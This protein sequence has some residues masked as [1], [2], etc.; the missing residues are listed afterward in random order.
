MENRQMAGD[1]D[2]KYLFEARNIHKRFGGVHALKGV[3]FNV[4]RG[5]IHGLV[6]ENGAGKSTLIKVISGIEQ[7]NE[8]ELLYNHHPISFSS[9]NDAM[10][11]GIA[12][13]HQEMSLFL[14]RTVAQ[15][16]FC[17]QEQKNSIG[18]INWAR[19]NQE[20]TDILAQLGVDLAP[21]TL[22]GDLSVADRQSIEIAKALTRKPDL[23]IMD[24]PT[25]ALARDEIRQLFDLLER[26]KQSGLTI[27]F[28][29]HKLDEVIEIC[30]HITVLR[31]GNVIGDLRASQTDIDSVIE[32][33]VGRK[34]E[35]MFPKKSRQV[36]RRLLS[37]KSFSLEGQFKNISFDLFEDEVLG[38]FGLLGAG[39]TPLAKAICGINP[40]DSG[41][42]IIGEEKLAI[43]QP[44]DAIKNGLL[45]MTEDR[46]HEGLFLLLSVAQN[47]LAS[48][49][50]KYARRGFLG[51]KKSR[52]VAMSYVD[53]LR[54]ATPGTDTLVAQLSGGNQQKVLLGKI[55]GTEPR[56]L[57]V[58]EPTRGIDV[59]AK[60]EIYSWLR[61]LANEGVGVIV[62][63]AE[64]PEIL[65]MADRVMVMHRGECK[66]F[67]KTEGATEESLLGM[68]YAPAATT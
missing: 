65:G 41:E 23:L 8:G 59:G 47:I 60:A 50:R 9:P 27:I 20:A 68:C 15:N 28:I 2:G 36:G 6:G 48:S 53:L 25:S 3:D 56:I 14:M 66:G 22:A 32:L 39:K 37:V 54:I 13:V 1:G 4:V 43:H 46:R 38:I 58:D 21:T 52:Q 24:E 26:L 40:K 34:L 18:L 33:M 51:K 29:S 55:L 7:P 62:I 17:R 49:L 64:L 61:R 42:V 44:P 5:E 10:A 35:T 31:D 45:Y 19:V 63:S 12:T 16:I 67:A 30:D 57:I 11:H